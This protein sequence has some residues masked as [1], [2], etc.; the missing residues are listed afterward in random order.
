MLLLDLDKNFKL[1]NDSLGHAAGDEVLAALAPRLRDVVRQLDTVARFGGDEF[2]VVAEDIQDDLEAI[3][4]AERLTAELGRPLVIS[5]GAHSVTGS[6]GVA[7]A[8]AGQGT[9]EALLRDADAAMYRAKENGGAG[10]QVFDSGMRDRAVAPRRRAGQRPAHGDRPPRVRARLPADHLPGHRCRRGRRGATA[11]ERQ[12]GSVDRSRRAHRRRRG[13]R[14]D[15]A[16]RHL[17]PGPGDR[18][19]SGLAGEPRRAVAVAER[20]LPP[21]RLF[22]SSCRS[23]PNCSRTCGWDP[24][25]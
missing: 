22:P 13:E 3:G 9:P 6:I 5:D 11:L 21:A 7:V 17:G 4:L 2:V 18:T 14:A 1:I 12:D 20:V 24:S 16:D 25:G 23:S 15:P 19:H 10:H 8:R